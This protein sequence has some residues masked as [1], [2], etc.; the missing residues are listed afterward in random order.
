MTDYT[1]SFQAIEL[2]YER[3]GISTAHP[4]FYDEPAFVRAE[5]LDG[6]FL[7]TY[8]RYVQRRQYTTEYLAKAD[9][10]VRLVS[11][12]LFDELCRD[13]RLGACI[14]ASMVLSRILDREDVWNYVV[15]GALTIDFGTGPD[16]VRHFWPIDEG[17]VATAAHVWVVA[18]PFAIVDITVSRQ[19]CGE[20]LR[21]RLP[22]LILETGNTPAEV[23]AHDICS[24]GT[25]R[26]GARQGFHGERVIYGY[27]PELLRFFPVFPATMV[28]RDQLSL[29]YVPCAIGASDGPLEAITSLRL[30]GRTGL[31]IYKDLIAPAIR[32]VV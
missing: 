26:E 29:K 25:R 9:S 14:D 5:Q 12:H 17:T 8:A 23:T 31:E 32:G 22:E 1:G 27:E 15:K 10:I 6:R 19:P 13:G 7:N 16:D 3:L 4:G 2:E 20:R 24:P 30:S 21:G 28:K 11:G 18:P